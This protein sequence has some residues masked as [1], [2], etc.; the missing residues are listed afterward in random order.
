MIII[1]LSGKVFEWAMGLFPT[2]DF[3]YLVIFKQFSN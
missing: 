2:G 1:V 3:E